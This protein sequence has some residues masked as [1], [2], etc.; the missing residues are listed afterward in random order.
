MKTPGRNIHAL[1][2]FLYYAYLGLFRPF[3]PSFLDQAGL[4]STQIGHV[5]M[6]ISLA[7]F[8]SAPAWGHNADKYGLRPIFLTSF[9]LVAAVLMLP[10]ILHPGFFSAIGIAL[11][12]GALV[13]PLVPLADAVTMERCEK[14]EW[15]YGRLRLW[16]TVGFLI[17][18]SCGGFIADQWGWMAVMILMLLL[19]LAIAVGGYALKASPTHSKAATTQQTSTAK[20]SEEYSP[21]KNPIILLFLAGTVFYQ[22][23]FGAY[24]LF[25]GIHVEK[26]GG[27]AKWVSISWTI[28]TFSEIL[29]FTQ[30]DRIMKRIGPVGLIMAAMIAA[31]L[32][33]SLMAYTQSISLILSLQILH[34]IMLGGFTTGTVAFAHRLF[35]KNLKTYGQGLHN[36]AYNG[37]GGVLAAQVA[38]YF[39]GGFGSATAFTV[40]A[41]LAVVALAA[42]ILGPARREKKDE[43][44]IVQQGLAS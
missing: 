14:F 44:E 17:T 12:Q 35:P 29:F 33:W 3:M 27:A 20:S 6:L 4:N 40:S 30:A 15:G 42:L 24:N 34:G 16:G 23:A 39:Y 13:V 41:I 2:Y 31:I 37:V 26:L 25:F 36:A 38:G 10:L 22:S 28:A 9:P 11:L 32:R 8:L 43:I 5:F 19:A 1:F 21:W 18:S 7:T